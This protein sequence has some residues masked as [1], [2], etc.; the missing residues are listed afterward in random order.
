MAAT[1]MGWTPREFWSATFFEFSSVWLALR[2]RADAV[3]RAAKGG[4]RQGR[5]V[6][7]GDMLSAAAASRVH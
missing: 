5:V 4:G 2:E 6:D 1:H 7:V 3:E